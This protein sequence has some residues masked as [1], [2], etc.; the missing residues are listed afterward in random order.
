MLQETLASYLRER[1]IL[2]VF[3]NFEHVLPAATLVSD[4]L[5][6]APGVKVLATSRAR[7]GLQAEREYR[8]EPL[9]IPDQESLP[10]LAV[11]STFD[12]VELFTSRA[13][14]LRPDF[15]LTNEN[16]STVAEIVCRLDGLPLAIELAAARVKLLSP[17][18]L[19]DRL[20]RRLSTLTGG[21]RDLPAR[22]RTLRDTIAWSHDLLD[23]PE[24][25]LFRRLSV[26]VGGW[27][28]EAAEAVAAVDAGETV[29]AFQ[30][31]ATLVDQSLV[32]EWPT[33][34]TIADEPRY[35]MLETIREFASEQLATSGE[36]IPVE[37]AFE[38]F[39]I[40]K[41]EA[42][43][44]GLRGPDQ[45]LWLDR[46]EAEHDNLRAALGRVLEREDGDIAVRLARRLWEFWWI[47]GHPGE[48]R[49][50]LERAL[51]LAGEE[52]MAGRAAAEF[53]LGKL[54]LEVGNYDTA[55]KHFRKSLDA[56]RQLGDAVVVAEVL[57]ALAQIAVNRLAYA[58][59]RRL[60]EEAVTIALDS[61]DRRGAATALRIL[62][63]VAR[64]QGEYARALE[65]LEE[66]MALW[67]S[68]GDSAWTAR[69]A[70]QLGITHRLAGNAEEAERFLTTSRQLHTEL[71]DRFALAVVASH[72]GHLAFDRGDVV[73]AIALYA[74]ALSGFES[75]GDPEGVLEA[76]EWL[77]VTAATRGDAVRA[78]RLFGA[79]STAREALHL[80]PRLES[81]EKRVAPA[82]EEAKK[83]AGTSATIALAEGKQLSLERARDEALDLSRVAAAPGTSSVR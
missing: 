47:R 15:S 53:G 23:A 52:D 13:Q 55:E 49:S 39:L 17:E 25:I 40:G 10:P 62:G 74:D 5:A 80:P 20:D 44:A 77:A 71:G 57:S 2:L 7:L 18:A 35:G 31:L 6:S 30:A 34:D 72:S 28:L 46:L 75:V 45:P 69:L 66:S 41:V 67:R 16:A 63:M 54:W 29:D 33:P 56:R 65:L 12:A 68:L 21:A 19:L 22:Q 9:P 8:V 48:G 73:R 27:T 37:R 60:G 79:A 64:E 51:A 59:A 78:L 50:W 11:L 3:D 81:D 82:I 42:A 24:K 83:A 4:L 70:S 43:E 38:T 61:G 76:I 26:F 58:E 32:D 1:H 14:A 36:I